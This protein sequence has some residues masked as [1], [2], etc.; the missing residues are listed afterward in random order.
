[1]TMDA[2]LTLNKD[3]MEKRK[4]PSVSADSRQ[5]GMLVKRSDFWSVCFLN[6]ALFFAGAGEEG[7]CCLF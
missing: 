4:S 7:Q 5:L 1:M 6:S 3:A 2:S